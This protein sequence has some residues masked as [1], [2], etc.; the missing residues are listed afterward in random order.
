M[1]NDM[2]PSE[3]QFSLN[4][5]ALSAPQCR[6]II[7]ILVLDQR[8]LKELAKL[9]KLTPSS[10]DKHLE[11]LV[12]AGLV[13]MRTVNGVKIAKLQTAMLEPTLK[14]FTKLTG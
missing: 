1:G 3:I 12:D 9:C 10:I 14:W 2:K 6:R 11:I 5:E 8:T 4:L 7:E 13:K